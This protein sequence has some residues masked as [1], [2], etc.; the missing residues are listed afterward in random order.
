LLTI[1]YDPTYRLDN[2]VH[3][4]HGG[5]LSAQFSGAVSLSGTGSLSVHTLQ[6]DATRTFTLGGGTLTLNKINLMPH[7]TTPATLDVTGD[8]NLNALNNAAAVIAN[9]TGGGSSGRIDLTGGIRTWNVG[10]G[11]AT[12]DLS[13]N[14]PIINGGLTKSGAG[15][16]ALN[17]ANTY[18]GDTSVLAGTLSL[19]SPFLANG[20]D[21]HLATGG[22][23][24]LNFGGS[25]DVV[26]SLFIDGVSQA[27]GT[28]GAVGNSAAD[29]QSPF[30]TGS[31]LLQVST[32]VIPPLAG[33][34]N[35]DGTV[36]AADFVVWRD[37]LGSGTSLPN[38]DTA[39]VGPDDWDRW[40]ANFGQTNGNGAGILNAAVPEP[41][42]LALIVT[43]CA[44]LCT[45]GRRPR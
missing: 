12:T 17:S 2:H 6:V 30:I 28:W 24:D 21:V 29:F 18:A 5:P 32:F 26:D 25:P 33:D 16:L 36:D 43:V 1:N 23:L 41:E 15:T 10:D 37:N 42:S 38:D 20:S 4:R 11:S 22:L 8:V 13:I 27:V 44:I 19:G 14:V 39:G 9:G 35:Q 31:G 40:V 45:L 3:V 34:Y 7:A